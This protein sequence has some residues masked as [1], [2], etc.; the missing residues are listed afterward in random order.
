M[1]IEKK[2]EVSLPPENIGS[3]KFYVYNDITT[4]F[5]MMVGIYFPSV[6]G[7]KAEA[8]VP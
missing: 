3:N 2:N 7:E 5:T 1:L 4:F 8:R 6:T